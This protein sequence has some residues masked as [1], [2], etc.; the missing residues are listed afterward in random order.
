MTEQRGLSFM[1]AIKDLAEEAGMESPPRPRWPKGPKSQA[2]TMRWRRR[3]ASSWRS[4]REERARATYLATRGFRASHR[5][6]GFGYAPE[7][8]QA[9]KGALGQLPEAC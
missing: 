3:R 1:D 2:C 5:E 6:F 8:R 9:M 4:W 7:G